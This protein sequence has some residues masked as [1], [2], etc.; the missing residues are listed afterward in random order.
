MDLPGA[1][2]L[3]TLKNVLLGFALAFAVAMV[4]GFVV[5]HSKIANRALYPILVASQTVPV[6]A[7][8]PIFIIW[9]GYGIMPKII[10]TALICFFPLTV[11]TIA[12]YMSVDPQQEDPV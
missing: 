3:L 1:R 12:G 4:L 10:T 9:F 2:Y 7:I 5:A 11:S 6:I 8:A